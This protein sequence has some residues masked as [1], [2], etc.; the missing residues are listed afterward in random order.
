[1]SSIRPGVAWPPPELAKV[2]AR[3]DECRVWWEGNPE[4]LDTF[5]GATGRTSPSGQPQ[6]GFRAAW[7][8]FWGKNN[9]GTG[10]APR[11]LHAPIAADIAQLS[12]A[13]LF[14]KPPTILAADDEADDV[15]VRVDDLYNVPRFHS[16]LYTAGEKASAL[17]G[18]YG[19]VAWD[20][21]IQQGTWI[22]WIAPDCAIPTWSRGRLRAVTFFTELESDD[23]RVVWRHLERYEMGRIVHELYKGTADNLGRL[24]TLKAHEATEDIPVQLGSDGFSYVDLGIPDMLAVDYVPNKLPNPE[25]D[26]DPKLCNL[27]GSDIAPDIIPLY[28]QIDRVYSSLMRDVRLSA[29]KVFASA[30]ILQNRGPGSGLLLPE[31][32]EMF[33]QLGQMMAKEGDMESIFQPYQPAMRVLEH[34]QAGE[35]LV[36]EV[37]RRTGYSPVSF[38][39]SDEVAQTA[40]EAVGKKEW[41]V[42]TT[43]GKARYFGT[44]IQHLTT[45]A[46]RIDKV[47]FPKLGVELHEPLDVDWPPFAQESDLSRAQTVQAWETG[48]SASTRTKVRYLHQDWTEEQID[49]EV[50]LIDEANMVET[51]PFFGSDTAPV[52]QGDNEKPEG[53]QTPEEGATDE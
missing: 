21:K 45:A 38:G 41:T 50:E 30:S 29:M 47:K 25:W 23:D 53:E 2:T 6:R 22:E 36:R 51:P 24:E 11:R 26:N 13:C 14:S 8:A 43:E 48:R 31:E 52:D 9:T 1:M 7:D 42:I 44:A 39:M 3:V 27:G 35:I 49:D 4:K 12:A 5:Y 46:L 40:T 33:T 19:R 17:T 28:H 34:D 37:L 15:Q 32:Q 18:V 10:E 16:G 20:D